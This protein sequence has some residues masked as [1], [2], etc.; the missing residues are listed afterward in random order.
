M[1]ITLSN[2]RQRSRKVTAAEAIEIVS[3]QHALIKNIKTTN[4]AAEPMFSDSK[5]GWGFLIRQL[6]YPETVRP[7][8]TLKKNAHRAMYF[9]P[10]IE[11]EI[12]RTID[13][14]RGE[15][16]PGTIFTKKTATS[17]LPPNGTMKLF[18]Q[19]HGVA[20]LFDINR[21]RIADKYVFDKNVG[22]DFRWWLGDTKHERHPATP[23]NDIRNQHR[24]IIQ[25]SSDTP[26]WNEILA[27]L[28]AD[29]II[30]VGIP[31]SARFENE[32][33]TISALLQRLNAQYRCLILQY[34]LNVEV[35]IFFI[36]ETKDIQEYSPERQSV[37]LDV[38]NGYTE[39]G[40]EGD[41]VR[42]YYKTILSLTDKLNQIK[43]LIEMT[44]AETLL[45][46]FLDGIQKD[47]WWESI[48]EPRNITI[49]VNL[50]S[51]IIRDLT[52]H[53]RII[54]KIE[55]KN[56][57]EILTRKIISGKFTGFNALHLLMKALNDA[58][59]QKNNFYVLEKLA[60]LIINIIEIMDPERLADAL[61]EPVATSNQYAF[62]ALEKALS[63]T[64]TFKKY[65]AGDDAILREDLKQRAI[66]SVLLKLILIFNN[67]SISSKFNVVSHKHKAALIWKIKNYLKSLEDIQ[68]IEAVIAPGTLIYNMVHVDNADGSPG[69]K[70]ILS[71][72]KIKKMRSLAVDLLNSEKK[73][74]VGDS[75]RLLEISDESIV[76][77][78]KGE[79]LSHY[80]A[81]KTAITE[82]T[83]STDDKIIDKI[84]YHYVQILL[85][86][87]NDHND[88]E[89]LISKLNDFSVLSLLIA[90]NYKMCFSVKVE[91]DE[92]DLIT[93]IEKVLKILTPNQLIS[94]LSEKRTHGGCWAGVNGFVLLM[95]ALNNASFKEN[96]T[97]VIEKITETI[98][99]LINKLTLDQLAT[100][101]SEKSTQ[102]DLA[103][104][105]GFFRLMNAL[106]NAASS[107]ENNTA[108]IE[109]ITKTIQLLSNKLTLDQLATGLSDK[110]T[111]GDWAGANGFFLLMNALNNASSKE[112]NTAVIEKITET[113]QLLIN[114][115]TP[116]QLA[117]GLSEKRTQGDWAGANGFLLLMNALNKA[118][119]KENN[120]T[121]IEKITETIQLLINKL[122]SDQL[123]EIL[124][125]LQVKFRKSVGFNFIL[126]ILAYPELKKITG[127]QN[128]LFQILLKLNYHPISE[129]VLQK[130]FT[131][132]EIIMKKLE[133]YVNKLSDS[134]KIEKLYEEK[135]IFDRLINKRKSWVSAFFKN[136]K[137]QEVFKKFILEQI[138][139]KK[140]IFF[141]IGLLNHEM[142]Q[143]RVSLSEIAT[144]TTKLNKLID[145]SDV[146]TLS[147]TFFEKKL[148][149]L[150]HETNAMHGLITA[151]F[152][153]LRKNKLHC[154]E[155]IAL[156]IK[157]L[158]EKIDI[159]KL[160]TMVN[161]KSILTHL[162]CLFQ[163]P[164]NTKT[165][166]MQTLLLQLARRLH[167]RPIP[168]DNKAVFFTHK[169]S[170]REIARR[171][172][173]DHC[174][175]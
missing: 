96:N 27:R 170:L 18:S 45:N 131:F 139:H 4:P 140:S 122:T 36:S 54:E 141:L 39:T 166:S 111:Q 24:K 110:R 134:D 3:N 167:G 53:D 84:E 106:N 109:K 17:L 67:H 95:K 163:T 132:N 21:C 125:R 82:N 104:A 160:D 138:R 114:K 10:R 149:D 75:A 113:I 136:D 29:S 7:V 71:I 161:R 19:Q 51:A 158:L 121:V 47:C 137:E 5:N 34:E 41:L 101:L 70:S 31:I 56:F 85:A 1:R 92:I 145:Q 129:D 12:T 50:F 119:S 66:L 135:T 155:A 42:D 13:P 94:T 57:I 62:S 118:S 91:R 126:E 35:P 23:I 154:V 32:Q 83:Q 38:A 105:N 148:L 130:L 78:N 156:T 173:K 11:K 6:Q 86:I 107:K 2:S 15:F 116:D 171:D 162:L 99:L 172:M 43:K 63:I 61:L 33:M 143:E 100:G 58:L 146:N 175:F 77:N 120:T 14:V 165:D 49:P 117:T 16:K 157:K 68:L 80:R 112:N 8:I 40:V 142:N 144:I 48:V 103:G 123:L 52:M 124:S 133:E 22:T 152:T 169:Y 28:S 147:N 30:G 25:E 59:V 37:D 74:I 102:D 98:Q 26:A 9:D 69:K 44:D 90:C 64:E 79:F 151:L 81:L 127:I 164:C 72:P 97:A 88:N 159:D 93:V 174:N 128:L 168:A 20:I 153:A 60:R 89:E 115:L 150:T 76:R 87:I 55:R 73:D 46:A 108:V 65:A